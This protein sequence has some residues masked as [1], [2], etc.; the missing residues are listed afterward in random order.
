MS[1]DEL[2]PRLFT[3]V[4]SAQVNY[5]MDTVEYLINQERTRR[6]AAGKAKMTEWEVGEF[7][8]QL[9]SKLII[10]N[11]AAGAINLRPTT[12]RKQLN[13]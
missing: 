1:P 2:P 4:T 11:D 9:I 5:N 6:A 7:R 10:Q 12:Q 13:G 8:R 3:V